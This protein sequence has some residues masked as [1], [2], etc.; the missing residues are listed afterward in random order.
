MIKFLAPKLAS[1]FTI[2]YYQKKVIIN[3]WEFREYQ[4][5]SEKCPVSE[6]YEELTLDNKVSADRFLEIARKLDQLEMPYFK[7]FRELWEAR[8][9]GENGVPH[10]IFCYISSHGCVTF[11]C[12]CTH[13]GRRYNP[14]NAYATAIKRRKEIQNG[15]A[16]T[17]ELSF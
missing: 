16:S 11:L 1:F 7:R 12:G 10:R 13:K 15:K 4:S 14:T 8:W 5:E 6:W 17:S 3:V 2:G 9:S